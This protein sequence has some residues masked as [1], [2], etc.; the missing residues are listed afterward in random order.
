MSIIVGHKDLW[1]CVKDKSQIKEF[2]LESFDTVSQSTFI[3][4]VTA[5]ECFRRISRGR[6]GEVYLNVP[7]L[8]AGD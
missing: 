5:K 1:T 8:W 6:D 3:A 4:V 7:A 2:G